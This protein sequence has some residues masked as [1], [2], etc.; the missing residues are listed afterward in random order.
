MRPAVTTALLGVALAVAAG[1]FDAEPLWVPAV[2]LVALSATAVAWVLAG[3]R[4][5]SVERDV[6]SRRVME[7]EPVDIVL[8]VRSGAFGIPTGALHDDL[9]PVPVPLR[10]GRSEQSTRLRVRFTRRG[11]RVLPAPYAEVRD[12]LGLA[13]RLVARGAAEAEVLVL[14]RVL[15]VGAGDGGSGDGVLGTR[16]RPR[17]AAE[18]D[19]DGVRGLRP[20]TPASRIYW[21]SF[22]RGGELMERRLQAEGD[23]RPLIV[24]DPRAAD[25]GEE[26]LDR[27]VRAVASLCVHLARAGGCAV[28][29]PG[30]RRATVLEPT[31]GGWP[32]L[33]VRLALVDAAGRPAL[34]GI[35]SRR[36]PVLYVAARAQTRAPRALLHAP[37]GGRILVVPVPIAG[38]RALFTVAGCHGYELSE[39][40]GRAAAA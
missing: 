36:G 24:L 1:L 26:A 6:G 23:T 25:G 10:P 22:A 35:A 34:G 30:D 13:T 20:G 2:A 27:A 21:P 32:H 16:G 18:V 15:P 11:R 38:R 4:S 28:L 31:L 9:L 12:P 19:I 37:G 39:P 5:I 14:P 8:C 17:I 7:E 29:L 40:A 33:H 3:A